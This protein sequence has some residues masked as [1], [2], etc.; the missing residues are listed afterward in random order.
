MK[1][2]SP[3]PFNTGLLYC[4]K[5]QRKVTG[6][7]Y[8]HSLANKQKQKQLAKKHD[9]RNNMFPWR[10]EKKFL[11]ENSFSP[12][13]FLIKQFGW[14]MKFVVKYFWYSSILLCVAIL[15]KW[16]FWHEG[17]ESYWISTAPWFYYL[18]ID[19]STL[20]SDLKY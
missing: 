12:A 13:S 1:Q 10:K 19:S 6:W 3:R 20:G 11:L 8:T 2:S 7:D 9:N 16:Y 5:Q 14:K 17:Q 15:R 4:I 18:W